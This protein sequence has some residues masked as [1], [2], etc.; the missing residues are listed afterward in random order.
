MN[1]YIRACPTS[2]ISLEFSDVLG[3]VVKLHLSSL[4]DVLRLRQRKHT[5]LCTGML[6]SEYECQEPDLKTHEV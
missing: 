4:E 3:E 2:Q 6:E 1:L 5:L